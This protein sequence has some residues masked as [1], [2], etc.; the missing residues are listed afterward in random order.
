MTKN[1]EIWRSQVSP[2]GAPAG[3]VLPGGGDDPVGVD[4]ELEAV[5]PQRE[6]REHLLRRRGQRLPRRDAAVER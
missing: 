2:P 3:D 1:T 4:E 6:V 5:A